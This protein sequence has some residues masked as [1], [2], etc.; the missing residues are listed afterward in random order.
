MNTLNNARSIKISNAPQV[1]KAH[2]II[3]KTI[4][5]TFL[6]I[7]ALAIIFPF[8]WM[9]A[10][11]LKSPFEADAMKPVFIP[12]QFMWTAWIE[13]YKSVFTIVPVFANAIKNTLIVGSLTTV[14]A[15]ITSF[16]SGYAFSSLNFKGKSILFTLLLATMMIPGEMMI[17]TNLT[18]INSFGWV[19][20]YQAMIIPFTVSVTY[21]FLMRQTMK[22]IPVELYKAAK[23][24]GVSD[25]KYLMRVILPISRPAIITVTILSMIGSWNAY[26]WPL[27]VTNG[28]PYKDKLLLVSTA[29]RN[30]F[31]DSITNRWLV[32][33]QMAA[34]ALVTIPLLIIFLLLKNYIVRG[35]ARSGI[36]G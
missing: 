5:Y 26:V 2:T 1:T 11:S 25:F 35:V 3:A 22:Q 10:T 20:T 13:N 9:L 34:A 19:N 16:L 28:I 33:V 24:D 31:V 18:T 29:L 27:A 21:I 6:I 36:K 15:V 4:S 8:Y 23:M 30:S 17:L 12:K 7:A 32:E 14:G